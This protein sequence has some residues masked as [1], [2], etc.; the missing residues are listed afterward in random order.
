MSPHDRQVNQ[1]IKE[2][3]NLKIIE[4]YDKGQWDDEKLYIGQNNNPIPGL[5]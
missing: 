2:A 3:H 5:L 1:V 4:Q